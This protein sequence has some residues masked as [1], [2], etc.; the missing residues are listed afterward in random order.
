[1][2]PSLSIAIVCKNNE[3]T[4]ARTLDSIRDLVR[5]FAGESVGGVGG[6]GG[7]G[8]G[9]VVAV[10]SGSTDGT[11][12]LLEAHNAR[13]IRS[14]WLGHIRTKQ[15]ALEACDGEWVLSLDSDESL[16]PDLVASIRAALARN[17]PAIA[18]YELNRKVYYRGKPLNHAW[19]PEWRLRLV[20]RGTCAWGGHDPHDVLAPT[21]P[22]AQVQR[23]AG[24]LRHD[25]IPTFGEF[26]I[27]QAAHSRTMAASLHA[28]GV[29][30]SYTR[31]LVSP[32]G[33]VFKQLVL[34]R[35]FLDGWPGW[36]AAASTGASALMKHAMLIELD[37]AAGHEERQ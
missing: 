26:L 8:G 18:A 37:R 23:L 13:I 14:P 25:S 10:D 33:A 36:L 24:T 27:K 28:A 4:L 5:E 22:G 29:R 20:R 35:A 15:L 30:G 1:M 7:G 34:K 11:I 2:R 12:A 6:G 17:D 16:E 19:Q 31:L 9:G 3:Q 32:I 21:S